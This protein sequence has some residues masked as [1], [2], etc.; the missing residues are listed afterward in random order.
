MLR[1]RTTHIAWV[2]AHAHHPQMHKRTR[3]RSLT[4]VP[5]ALCPGGD[6]SDIDRLPPTISR[7]RRDGS[8]GGLG[9]TIREGGSG[10]STPP[11]AAATG[12]GKPRSAPL[13]VQE[14]PFSL[15]PK[16]LY[17]CTVGRAMASKAQ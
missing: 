14:L 12:N 1:M 2:N 5:L 17:T 16:H 15:P 4:P 7:H 9:P 3:P 6:P 10:T 11:S 8:T 13:R